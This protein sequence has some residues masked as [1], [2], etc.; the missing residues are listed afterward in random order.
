M[1]G[2]RNEK[3]KKSKTGGNKFREMLKKPWIFAGAALLLDTDMLAVGMILSGMRPEV[4]Y[5]LTETTVERSQPFAFF[6]IIAAV[7][8]GIVCVMVAF[9]IAGAFLK[10]R[11]AA[12]FVG[13]AGLLAVSLVMIGVSA[14]TALGFPPKSRN[15]I[16]YSDEN[17]RLIIEEEEQFSGNG[18]ALFFLTDSDGSGR[19]ELIASTDITEYSAEGEERYTVSWITDT[20]MVI[21]FEDGGNYRTLQADVGKYDFSAKRTSE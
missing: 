16:S 17:L 14:L 4:E 7:A 3:Q 9:I 13:A 5:T 20:I 10:K 19:V 21:G 6:G 8:V 2:Y 15:Y 12:S 18:T 11:R 1:S